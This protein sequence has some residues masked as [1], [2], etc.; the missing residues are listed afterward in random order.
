MSG[1]PSSILNDFLRQKVGA[2]RTRPKKLKD[3]LPYLRETH[4]EPLVKIQGA[5]DE[6]FLQMANRVTATAMR[7]G[8]DS[9]KY[10]D[11]IQSVAD[12]FGAKGFKSAYA[13]TWYR[14]FVLSLGYNQSQLQI[15]RDTPAKRL[16]PYLRYHT[17]RDGAVRPEHAR[18]E[19]MTAAADWPL[20]AS[21]RPPL[22]WSCRCWLE[23]LSW[24]TARSLRLEG[25]IAAG[26]SA[27]EEFL[28]LGGA[29][30]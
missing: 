12:L 27:A 6:Q 9:V 11:E 13:S 22:G 1:S 20:W 7:E 4:L 28:A 21:F 24:K 15:L 26:I 23:K 30:F 19:G 10:V 14:T 18:L 2:Q 5:F 3:L 29:G 16:F 25:D 17:M 8:W